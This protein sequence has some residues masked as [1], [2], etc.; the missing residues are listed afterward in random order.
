ML[1]L[2]R[3]QEEQTIS[4]FPASLVSTRSEFL[5]A[6]WICGERSK[7]CK[8]GGTADVSTGNELRSTDV[9]I[10]RRL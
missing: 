8:A 4:P 10:G 9:S 5:I 2:I 1:C 6:F 3:D 7:G